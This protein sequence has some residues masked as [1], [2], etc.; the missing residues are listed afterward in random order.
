MNVKALK[1]A[2]RILER[3]IASRQKKLDLLK[4]YINKKNLNI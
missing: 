4:K 3:E 1:K 2:I